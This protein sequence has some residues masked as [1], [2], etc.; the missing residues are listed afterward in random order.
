MCVEYVLC[1]LI[2]ALEM[3]CAFAGIMFR[4]ASPL[5]F[6]PSAMSA[7]FL[8][9]LVSGALHNSCGPLARLLPMCGCAELLLCRACRGDRCHALLGFRLWRYQCHSAVLDACVFGSVPWKVYHMFSL[10][11]M[12]AFGQAFRVE[13]LVILT[14]SR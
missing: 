13:Q 8:G 3:K 5:I 10:D 6:D 2:I 14:V 12:C 11:I 7:V 9:S 4:S 1:T